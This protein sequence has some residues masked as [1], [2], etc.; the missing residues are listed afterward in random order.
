MQAALPLEKISRRKGVKMKSR[1]DTKVRRDQ[2]QRYNISE[3][4]PQAVVETYLSMRPSKAMRGKLRNA[5]SRLSTDGKE[6]KGESER[7]KEMEGMKSS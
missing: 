5:R 2:S 3:L 4:G 7:R 1:K 6:R